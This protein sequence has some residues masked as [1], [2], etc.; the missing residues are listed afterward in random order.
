VSQHQ[1]VSILDFIFRMME[2]VV[3]TIDVKKRSRKKFKKTLKN[4]TKI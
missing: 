4:V 3:T 2:V 1:S